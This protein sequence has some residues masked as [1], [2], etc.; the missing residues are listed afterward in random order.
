MKAKLDLARKR[1]DKGEE[2]SMY[3]T[4]HKRRPEHPV[5]KKLSPA[6]AELG[7]G[8]GTRLKS[9][10]L[11]KEFGLVPRTMGNLGRLLDGGGPDPGRDLSEQHPPGLSPRTLPYAPHPLPLLFANLLLTVLASVARFT[12]RAAVPTS[13]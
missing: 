2:C 8:I 10:R 5:V 1:R 13:S 6:S 11:P 4:Q 9:V 7:V 3:R 12:G